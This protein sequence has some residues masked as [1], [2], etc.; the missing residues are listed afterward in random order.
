[1]TVDNLLDSGLT[2]SRDSQ[3]G[4]DKETVTPREKLT[5]EQL[6]CPT[7]VAARV[8]DRSSLTVN[9]QLGR[10]CNA[11][12]EEFQ[13]FS[14]RGK[15]RDPGRDQVTVAGTFKAEGSG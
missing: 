3:L 4:R 13:S 12:W 9:Q 1:M 5:A 7:A 8:T 10:C 2:H 15:E 6:G 11:P 14:G